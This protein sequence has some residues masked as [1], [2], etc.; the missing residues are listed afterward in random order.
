MRRCVPRSAARDPTLVIEHK[1][2]L[3]TKGTVVRSD[4]SVG[5]IGKAAVLRPGSDVTVVGTLLMAARA[6]AA[7]DQLAAERIDAEVIDLQWIRPLDV[8]TVA[9]SVARTGRLVIAEEQ[10][11]AGG[12]GATLVSELVRR[13]VPFVATP[14]VVG[15]DDGLLIPYTP[16]V[17]DQIIPSSERI[18]QACRTAI[19]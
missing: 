18:A 2:L 5:E 15:L 11:H 14:E 9:E 19:A 13:G 8:A 6:T 4:A 3:T 10:H 12:W 1:A 7:A 17:E 16:D